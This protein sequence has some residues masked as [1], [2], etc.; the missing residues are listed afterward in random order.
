MGIGH[1]LRSKLGET[2]EFLLLLLPVSYMHE[3]RCRVCACV[4]Y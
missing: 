1:S 2:T 4:L 3:I